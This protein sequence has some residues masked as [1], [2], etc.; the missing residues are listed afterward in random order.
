MDKRKLNS[1]LKIV[2]K[3]GQINVILILVDFD[4]T[5]NFP[6]IALRRCIQESSIMIR[7]NDKIHCLVRVS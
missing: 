7:V 2:R 3:E 6:Y 5:E 4:Y 1:F